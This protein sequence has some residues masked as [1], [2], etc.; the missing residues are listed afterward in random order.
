MSTIQYNNYSL[1]SNKHLVCRHSLDKIWANIDIPK[2]VLIKLGHLFHTK[3]KK[4]NDG[5]SVR[6]EA[7][8]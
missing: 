5:P 6:E 8:V 1:Y 2:P 3:K 4:K 7:F